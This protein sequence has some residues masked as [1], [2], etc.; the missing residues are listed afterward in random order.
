MLKYVL[1]VSAVIYLSIPHL[2]CMF[3]I[4]WLCWLELLPLVIYTASSKLLFASSI[5][6]SSAIPHPFRLS[7]RERLPLV[8]AGKISWRKR[9]ELKSLDPFCW[10]YSKETIL[11]WHHI[12]FMFFHL[13][14]FLCSTCFIEIKSFFLNEKKWMNKSR[15]GW[16]NLCVR[17]LSYATSW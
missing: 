15:D 2:V 9:R 11:R 17:R 16:I 6:L 8:D 14:L 13:L 4:V 12:Q 10:W 7:Q 1:H 3:A 5:S